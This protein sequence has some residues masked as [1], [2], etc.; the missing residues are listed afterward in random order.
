MPGGAALPGQAVGVPQVGDHSDWVVGPDPVH[1]TRRRFAS[2][3]TAGLTVRLSVLYFRHGKGCGDGAC[4]YRKVGKLRTGNQPVQSSRNMHKTTE[5]KLAGSLTAE[6]TELI[7]FLPYLL[8]DFW[9][10]GSDPNAMAGLIKKHVGLSADTTLLDLA[11][12]KGAVS[13]KAAQKLQVRVKGV[14]LL[15][16]FIEFA[17]QKAREYG[18]ANLCD[19][20]VG[21]VNEAVATEKDYDIVVLGAVGNVLGN[22]RETLGKL[23]RTVKTGGHILID[24]SYLKDDGKP[25]DIR[26][27]NYE[28][29]TEKQWAALFA[30]SGLELVETVSAS[31][32]ESSEN[33]D[34]VSAMAAITQRANELTEKHPDK[35]AMFEGYIR[36]QQNEYN[37]LDNT[38]ESVVWILRKP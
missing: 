12:G 15:P 33:L 22:P 35:K 27:D 26:Y 13:V 32:L 31:E 37:D 7:P 16:E 30:E 4:P 34:G 38:L 18:V 25:E 5:E 6:T 23:K 1:L 3:K 9:E 2:L 19:F 14:D 36:S 28:Y 29:L 17:K 20:A 24:E 11:C 21:D 8:Q 10:L